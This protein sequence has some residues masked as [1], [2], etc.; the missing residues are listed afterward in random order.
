MALCKTFD[1]LRETITQGGYDPGRVTREQIVAAL[2][3]ALPELA[4]KETS[5]A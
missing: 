3:E 4:V 2:R 5:E 1:K